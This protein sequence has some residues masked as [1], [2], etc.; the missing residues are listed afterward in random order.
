MKTSKIL[1]NIYDS[2]NLIYNDERWRGSEDIFSRMIADDE[3]L[4]AYDENKEASGFLS[5]NTENAGYV[6]VTGLYV[7][8]EFQGKGIASRLME[9]LKA[10][11]GGAVILAEIINNAEWAKNFYAKH[12]F[13]TVGEDYPLSDDLKKLIDHNKWSCIHMFCAKSNEKIGDKK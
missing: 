8:Q 13:V 6:V 11:S 10:A 7:S 9:Q 5:Y 12:G 3:I 4:F 1:L 2:A